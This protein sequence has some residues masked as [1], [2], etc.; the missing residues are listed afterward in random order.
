M[1]IRTF[2]AIAGAI[3]GLSVLLPG[4]A[5]AQTGTPVCF[6]GASTVTIL[7]NTV[8]QGS[9]NTAFIA[10]TSLA[11]LPLAQKIQ[12]AVELCSLPNGPYRRVDLGGAGNDRLDYITFETN[13]PASGISIN[14]QGIGAQ[15]GITPGV[16]ITGSISVLSGSFTITDDTV[17][18]QIVDTPGP[19]FIFFDKSQGGGAQVS[20]LICDINMWYDDG[21]V[22]WGIKN[23]SVPHNVNKIVI[24]WAAG[25]S[26]FGSQTNVNDACFSQNLMQASTDPLDPSRERVVGALLGS[27]KSVAGDP[28]PPANITA[29]A[30]EPELLV[31]S[32]MVRQYA[33]YCDPAE[34]PGSA[35]SC[36]PTD[37]TAN[38]PDGIFLGVNGLNSICTGSSSGT[39]R[40]YSSWGC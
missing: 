24:G 40:S 8:C 20:T 34:P 2:F 3:L 17:I 31:E 19:E 7:Q 11:S 28:P 35:N 39:L 38:L 13:T 25:P 16:V 18:S 14:N 26:G 9:R 4:N 33:S 21:T 23:F 10:Q 29:C 27:Y 30:P 6:D 37:D 12:K 32:E 15:I 22:N 5:Q 36:N 1:S